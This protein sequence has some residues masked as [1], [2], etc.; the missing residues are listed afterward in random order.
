MPLSLFP[1]P[2][3]EGTARQLLPEDLP[4]CVCSSEYS[5]RTLDQVGH[6]IA[7]ISVEVVWSACY[8]SVRSFCFCLF[9]NSPYI[10]E[11]LFRLIG[12]A[13]ERLGKSV[14]VGFSLLPFPS[15]LLRT[16]SSVGHAPAGRH[17]NP[18]DWSPSRGERAGPGGPLEKGSQPLTLSAMVQKHSVDMARGVRTDTP[19][20]LQVIWSK[21]LRE[22]LNSQTALKP[23]MPRQRV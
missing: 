1:P 21:K 20:L 17:L 13:K 19:G 2:R 18:G 7:F 8:Q 10:M 3:P 15:E 6:R 12:W 22:V 16:L 11:P 23:L 9:F 14:T 4:S 5:C